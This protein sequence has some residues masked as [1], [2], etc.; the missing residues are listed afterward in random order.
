MPA[1]SLDV[2]CG[3]VG[4]GGD[5]HDLVDIAVG[6]IEILARRASHDHDRLRGSQ[7]PVDRQLCP[8]L[9]RIQHPLRIILRR[10]A[11]VV[12]HPQAGRS[13]C[14]RGEGVKELRVYHHVRIMSV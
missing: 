8:G 9:Q 3:A 5:G 6:I 1:G 11:Q 2:H 7:V 13:L 12:V 14:L 4:A 10:V